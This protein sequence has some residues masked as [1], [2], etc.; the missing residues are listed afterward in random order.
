MFNSGLKIFIFITMEMAF[1][2]AFPFELLKYHQ[3]KQP[4]NS[5][6]SK[7]DYHKLKHD[8]WHRA[9]ML[10]R[11]VSRHHHHHDYSDLLKMNSGKFVGAGDVSHESHEEHH[12]FFSRKWDH[13]IPTEFQMKPVEK[14]NRK[15]LVVK[16][17]FQGGSKFAAYDYDNYGDYSYDDL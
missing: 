11:G 8:A 4:T 6:V 1:T 10:V 12:Q 5:P 9:E 3:M 13:Y 16:K 15:W 17:A 2:I 14:N 7:E